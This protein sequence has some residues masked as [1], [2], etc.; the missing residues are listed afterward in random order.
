MQGLP[1]RTIIG[2]TREVDRSRVQ[3]SFLAIFPAGVLE[4]APQFDAL[5]TRTSGSAALAAVV[6]RALVQQFPNVSAIDLGL[7]LSTLNDIIDKISFVIR[8]MAGF[9][10]LTGLASAQQLGGH[11]PLPAGA[12][13]RA[14][15]HAGRQP[16][17]DSAHHAD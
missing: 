9:S 17:P 7:I 8:F 6:Q 1:Q 15:A 10:I 5:L 2:G 14:A 11:Q 16:G 3:P 12:R 13:E 4:R